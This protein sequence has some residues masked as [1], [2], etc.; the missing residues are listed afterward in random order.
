MITTAEERVVEKTSSMDLRDVVGNTPL[1]ELRSVSPNPRVRILAKPE[2]GNPGGSV[3]DRPAL[4]M[5]SN[6]ETRGELTREKTI[7]EPTSGNTGIAIAM[8]GAARGYRVKLVMP[9]CVSMERRAVLSAF[10]AE[11]VLSPAQQGTDGAIRMARK[12]LEEAPD[13]YYMPNQYA[14]PDNPLA[15]YETTGP[16]VLRQTGG[17][18]DCFVA[19]MGTGGTLMGVGRYMRENAPETKIIG[20]EP[21]LGHCIQGLKN[22]KEAIV[23]P[24]YKEEI[25]DHKIVAQDEPA[26]L[27]ARKLAL[28]EGLFVG[29]SSGAAVYGA[30][31]AARDMNCGTI[32][33]LL[34]D[35]GDRYLS[36]SLFR[37]TCGKCP[38]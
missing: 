20:V 25:L 26:F 27:T 14:N 7:L 3:K 6:A 9:A 18:I 15:H 35:R 2:G 5:I 29:M 17:E 16:E 24:I 31:E 10:G 36:T 34:P 37:S 38:P 32:V 13:N 8:L 28:E 19:G 11:L 33:V 30:I 1:I 4:Y 21:C 22:M 12:I 23:P